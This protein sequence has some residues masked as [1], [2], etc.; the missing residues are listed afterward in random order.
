VEPLRVLRPPRAAE[1]RILFA[2]PADPLAL[3]GLYQGTLPAGPP[4]AYDHAPLQCR[5]YL[6]PGGPALLELPAPLDPGR[7]HYYLVSASNCLGEGSR[8]TRSDGAPRPDLP[9]DC[10]PLR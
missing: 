3:F 8:G 1:L 5:V 2:D 9:A 7:S 4:F 6:P 10:G